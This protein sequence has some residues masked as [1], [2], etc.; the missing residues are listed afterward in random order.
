MFKRGRQ[1]YIIL[2]IIFILEILQ[3]YLIKGV[4]EIFIDLLILRLLS[5][6]IENRIG[7]LNVFLSLSGTRREFY[8]LTVIYDIL[9]S[10]FLSMVITLAR[11]KIDNMHISHFIYIFLFYIVVMMAFFS[12]LSFCQIFKQSYYIAI[13]LIVSLIYMVIYDAR[14]SMVF[15]TNNFTNFNENIVFYKDFTLKEFY[16]MFLIIIG[17]NYI[18][19]YLV[20][21]STEIKIK[22]EVE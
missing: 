21:R 1:F 9:I 17:F 12:T 16:I 10:I 22:G 19:S 5:I 3:G 2:F 11:V 14:Y 13:I 8:T 20:H 7:G 18:T 4:P 15:F 6:L